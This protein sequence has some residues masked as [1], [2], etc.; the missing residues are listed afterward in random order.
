MRQKP[1]LAII[2]KKPEVY[3]YKNILTDNYV[4]FGQYGKLSY[5]Y[6]NIFL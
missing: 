1:D 6:L 4:I 5:C 2:F 3:R